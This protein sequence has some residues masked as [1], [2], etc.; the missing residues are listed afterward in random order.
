MEDVPSHDA[1]VRRIQK[2]VVRAVDK[3]GWS[4]VS[5]ACWGHNVSLTVIKKIYVWRPTRFEHGE[6]FESFN[7]GKLLD[8]HSWAEDILAGRTIQGSEWRG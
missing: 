7:L 4:S 1:F 5:K 3:I 8:A 2:D 6:R